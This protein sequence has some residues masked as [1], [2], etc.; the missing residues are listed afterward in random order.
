[1]CR[2]LTMTNCNQ[3][4]AHTICQLYVGEWSCA[5]DVRVFI[6][7]CFQAGGG[8]GRPLYSRSD[9]LATDE[10]SHA[11]RISRV[12]RTSKQAAQATGGESDCVAHVQ[13]MMTV[14]N[15]QQAA[16][17]TVR[18]CLFFYLLQRSSTLRKT[19]TLLKDRAI[20]KNS[21]L[22]LSS[23]VLCWA[24]CF[25]SRG[26]FSVTGS[27]HSMTLERKKKNMKLLWFDSLEATVD[28]LCP[29]N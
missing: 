4:L 7:P 24:I 28:H 25:L 1:M 14:F 19:Y 29:V 21:P 15:T 16:T 6:P 8:P 20:C 5:R 23:S 10:F 13:Y 27:S 9:I 17:F 18:D 2:S 12:L 22:S 11:A 3:N 26:S